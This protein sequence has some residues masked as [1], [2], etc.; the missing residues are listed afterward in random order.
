MT[1]LDTLVDGDEAGQ[2][3]SVSVFCLRGGW[4]VAWA[5]GVWVEGGWVVWW[6]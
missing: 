6:L 5:G 1:Q 4:G 2:A 3:V